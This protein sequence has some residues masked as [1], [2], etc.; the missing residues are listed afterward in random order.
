MAL[1]IS[2]LVDETSGLN[3][4]AGIDGKYAVAGTIQMDSCYPTGGE[5]LSASDISAHGSSITALVFT[6]SAD[7]QLTYEWDSTNSKIVA[8]YVD[9]Q[10]TKETGLS[11]SSHVVTPAGT[12]E[13]ILRGQITAGTNTGALNLQ[14]AA[15]ANSLDGQVAADESTVTC[16]AADAATAVSLTYL[17]ASGSEV[18]NAADLSGTGKLFS[19]VGFV[20]V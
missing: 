19:Y 10:L 14:D 5:A 1:T 15:P 16:L 9:R 6:P 18:A 20:A 17:A 13:V 4:Q 3:V 2:K 7:G 11:P 8:R 12:P